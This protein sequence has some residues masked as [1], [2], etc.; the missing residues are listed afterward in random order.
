M[1]NLFVNYFWKNGIPHGKALANPSDPLT[2]K[3]VADPYFKH[4]SI[5]EYLQGK[6][7]RLI[8]NSQLLD[9]RTLRSEIP[10]SWSKFEENNHYII[11]DHNDRVCWI[12]NYTFFQNYCTECKVSSPHGILLSTHMIYYTALDQPFNG[13]VLLDAI[14]NK[15]MYKKYSLSESGEF[16][17]IIEES[18]TPA[19]CKTAV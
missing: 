19:D 6:F 17:T 11:R 2:Y 13:L 7:N 8:Y 16:D 3:I 14:G 18:W 9:F 12:E 5:E 1:Q 10:P 15:V 4:I